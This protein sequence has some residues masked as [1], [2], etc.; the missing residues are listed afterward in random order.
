MMMKAIPTVTLLG[1]ATR[2]AS[3]NPRVMQLPN[4]VDVHYSTW[5]SLLPDGT[6]IERRGIQPD[7]EVAHKGD[8]DQTFASAC[9]ALDQL[10]KKKKQ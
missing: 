6:S 8:G 7:I 4:G 1:Q 3:G 5:I 10:L 2:G 9:V